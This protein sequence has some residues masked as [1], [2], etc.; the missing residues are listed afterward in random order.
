MRRVFRRRLSV[1]AAGLMLLCLLPS[2][3]GKALAEGREDS[4]N[5]ISIWARTE[6][7]TSGVSKESELPSDALV[8]TVNGEM[9]E[10]SMITRSIENAQKRVE[11]NH[12]GIRKNLLEYDDVMNKQ[13]TVIY[14]K[15]RHAL[16]GAA[17]CRR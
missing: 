14:E 5:K 6:E 3:T 7:P 1:M 10:H 8:L 17:W 15:R 13:R 11:E 2:L 9:I 12:F 4:R 16:I